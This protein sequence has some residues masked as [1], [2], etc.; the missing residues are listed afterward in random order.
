MYIVYHILNKIILLCT[1][2]I[3]YFKIFTVNDH[4][5]YVTGYGGKCFRTEND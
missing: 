1:Y 2:A 5:W 4:V 3:C